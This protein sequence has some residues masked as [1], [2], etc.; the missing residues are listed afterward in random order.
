MLLISS[1]L[2]AAYVLPVTTSAVVLGISLATVWKYLVF[3]LC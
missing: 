1:F 2:L 3:N